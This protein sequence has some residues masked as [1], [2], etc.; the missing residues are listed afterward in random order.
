MRARGSNI[1]EASTY[2]FHG[3]RLLLLLLLILLLLFLL[4]SMPELPQSLVV[5]RLHRTHV[6]VGVRAG[7]RRLQVDGDQ[8]LVEEQVRLRSAGD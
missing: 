2:Q 5:G 8:L 7:R 1:Q 4:V 3:K 6:H